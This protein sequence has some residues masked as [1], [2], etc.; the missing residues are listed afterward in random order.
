MRRINYFVGILVCSV[1]M[2]PGCGDNS[3][4]CGPGTTAVD[5]VCTAGGTAG[6]GAGTVQ[7]GDECVPDGTLICDQGTS[8][9][10]DSGKC[11]PDITSCGP[12]MVVVDGVCVDVAAVTADIS[13]PAEP[14]GFDQPT[15][16]DA[17]A[18]GSMT[19]IGGCITPAGD[20]E[21]T[22]DYDVYL[23]TVAEP[24]LLQI[25]VDG[26]G[27]LAGG[28]IMVTDDQEL[29]G[30]GWAR[31]GVNLVDDM[32]R[33][34]VYLPRA[35]SYALA[36]TDSRS[37]L[38]GAPAGSDGTC[39]LATIR[40][41][42]IPA[43]IDVEDGAS[44][45]LGGE[46]QLYRRTAEDGALYFNTTSAPSQAALVDM[47][48]MVNDGYRGSSQGLDQR[49]VGAPAQTDLGGL[50]G[51]DEVVYVID[52]VINFALAPV[53]FELSILAPAAIALPA[54]GTATIETPTYPEVLPFGFTFFDVE[55][56]DVVYLDLTTDRLDSITMLIA[57]SDL[58]IVSRPCNNGC[59][60]HT[61]WFRFAE[62]GRYYLAMFDDSDPAPPPF[63]LTAERESVQPAAVTIGSPI[64]GV[65]LGQRGA[66]FYTLSPDT[67]EWWAFSGQPQGFGGSMQLGFHAGVGTGRLGSEIAQYD[68]FELAM[69]TTLGRIADQNDPI[70]VMVSD[71]AMGQVP[72]SYDLTVADRDYTDLGTV[73]ESMPY[74]ATG[75]DIGA[76]EAQ[77][78]V[79]FGPAFG[80]VTIAAGGTGSFD[81]IITRLGR[82]EQVLGTSNQNGADAAET[83]TVALAF[84]PRW[85][86]FTVSN[87]GGGAGAYDLAV[88]S[89]DPPYQVIDGDLPLASICPRDGGNG[90]LVP[91]Q[92]TSIF[93]PSDEGVSETALP[94]SFSF[95]FFGAMAGELSVSSNGWLNLGPPIIANSFINVAIP[96]AAEPNNLIAPLWDDFELAE[97]CALV[98]S[99]RITVQWS[100]VSF[101]TV[102]QVEMQAVLHQGGVIDLIYGT[103]HEAG[104][105]G[106]TIG[107][108]DGTGAEGVQIGFDTSGLGRPGTSITLSPN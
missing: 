37:I 46:V 79:V 28:F 65:T 62:A 55:A 14:N 26:Y 89:E 7:I 71:T 82:A 8:Y 4:E 61:G 32:A 58:F 60:S 73:S 56:G 23:L 51:G 93:D 30:A 18:L 90:E 74:S 43:P 81:S 50:Y 6:C 9:D 75:I 33:R 11:Q 102:D 106:A 5:G 15:T 99:D 13:E 80:S 87:A 77:R 36:I 10:P 105:A 88:T 100:A 53:P 41:A 16:V 19:T 52:P 29:D 20:P 84:R 3:K 95:P 59:T 67:F 47:V 39:Y 49:D 2:L 57:D 40:N 38:T 103:G 34:E 63:Q 24:T 78:Y 104:S 27:G 45:E 91:L 66:D 68:G 97:I 12:D 48:V 101:G 22:I 96:T 70:L 107:I 17:P 83:A 98:E 64:S 85:V 86:A 21:V 72:G 69:G 54:S 25:T 92:P 94:I 1:A 44:G 76:G 35:G 108:E 31:Y 42:E